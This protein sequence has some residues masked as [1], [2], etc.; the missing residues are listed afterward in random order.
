MEKTIALAGA[1][2]CG[3]TTLFNLITGSRAAT[4]NWAGVTVEKKIGRLKSDPDYEVVDLPGAYSL[5][6]YSLEESVTRDFLLGRCAEAVICVIDG[7]KP[8]AGIYLALEF[9]SLGVPAVLAVNFA[10]ELRKMGGDVNLTALERSSASP[11]F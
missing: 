2:N 3:K 10:D 9:R 8:E 5:T 6:P 4:G 11:P 7:T 1:P